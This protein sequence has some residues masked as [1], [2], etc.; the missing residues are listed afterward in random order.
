MNKDRQG[1]LKFFI[2]G[3]ILFE[4]KEGQFY[5]QI[6]GSERLITLDLNV[7]FYKDIDFLYLVKVLR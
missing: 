1:G 7:E 3:I 5:R 4:S 2:V 6:G